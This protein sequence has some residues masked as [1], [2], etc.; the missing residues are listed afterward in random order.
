MI[1]NRTE[2][3]FVTGDLDGILIDGD[4]M[5]L[6][7]GDT[8]KFDKNGDPISR[9]NLLRG[10]DICFLKEAI[11]ERRRAIARDDDSPMFSKK[12]LSSQIVETDAKL[13]D[14]I[15]GSG[16]YRYCWE[17]L[18]AM[19]STSIDAITETDPSS[20]GYSYTP[21]NDVI[22]KWED[23]GVNRISEPEPLDFSDGIL[24]ASDI[25]SLFSCVGQMKYYTPTKVPFYLPL[26]K[27]HSLVDLGSGGEPIRVS[28]QEYKTASDVSAFAKS[29]VVGADGTNQTVFDRS[30]QCGW[31]T[32]GTHPWAGWESIVSS[33]SSYNLERAYSSIDLDIVRRAIST[34]AKSC[35]LFGIFDVNLSGRSV[36]NRCFYRLK[37]LNDGFSIDSS[38]VVSIVQDIKNGLGLQSPADNVIYGCWINLR[39]YPVYE[40]R[41][42]TRW[43]VAANPQT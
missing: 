19:P 41:D 2:Y 9:K 10:E 43:D 27:T 18:D 33:V 24:R 25:N 32:T 40:L 12:V 22:S 39:L 17:W 38:R 4:I 34:Y 15:F 31:Q 1:S 16:V 35:R 3:E 8:G 5:P 13:R 37:Y 30:C 42:R 20:D 23:F 11:E 36:T 28:Y 26:T 29:L 14:A 21:A 6:R 7:T